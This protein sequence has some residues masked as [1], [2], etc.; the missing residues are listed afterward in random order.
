MGKGFEPVLDAVKERLTNFGVEGLALP[1]YKQKGRG[2][3][4]FP[5]L[6]AVLLFSFLM[7]AWGE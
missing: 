5:Y 7:F 1:S 4:A 2:Q 6:E 3:A